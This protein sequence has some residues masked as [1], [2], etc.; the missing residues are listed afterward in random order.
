ML[1]ILPQLLA[2]C[3]GLM[4]SHN[5]LSHVLGSPLSLT[6]LG[7]NKRVLSSEIIANVAGLTDH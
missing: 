1:L 4:V 5:P 7:E 3:L 6:M 2:P